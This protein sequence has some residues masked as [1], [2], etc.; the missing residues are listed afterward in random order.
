MECAREVSLSGYEKGKSA[1][2]HKHNPFF[3]ICFRKG[4]VWDL[5]EKLF[6]MHIRNELKN[7]KKV[8]VVVKPAAGKGK[9]KGKA[10]EKPK[11]VQAL[12][13]DLKASDFRGL[14]G[15]N[16]EAILEKLLRRVL[17][18][19][20]SMVEMNGEGKKYKDLK[21]TFNFFY[22]IAN[23][24]RLEDALG[25]YPKETAPE[26]LEVFLPILKDCISFIQPV[27]IET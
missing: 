25:L 4:V 7:Q 17:S 13:E 20:L 19:E 11:V 6:D 2:I 14:Q 22:K 10:Q 27:E 18:K 26:K 12:A 8:E 21:G 1:T 23:C 9:G 15:H 5:Q 16:D 24:K 3:Q